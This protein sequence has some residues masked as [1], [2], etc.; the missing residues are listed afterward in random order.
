MLQH[1]KPVLVS[2]FLLLGLA[3]LP[4]CSTM[5]R[6]E[7]LNVDWRTLGYEDGTHGYGADRIG[8]HRKACADYGVRPDLDAYRSGREEGLREFCRPPRG[9]RLGVDGGSY[10]GVCP[11]AL[12]G[13]FLS[14]FRAG[15]ELYVLRARVAAADAALRS[16]ERQI[17]SL[18]HGITGSAVAVNDKEA[19]TEERVDAVV[20]AANMAEKMG[21]L[22]AELRQLEEDRAH[23]QVELDD[24]LSSHPPV[25]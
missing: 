3:L 17:E 24:Y 18:E 2:A 15:H 25:E 5:S 11:A 13:R 8:Q 9:Y 10:G 20:D 23:Y 12:E 16:H 1:R 21:R 22:R 7:C 19:S 6:K 14:A 4:G